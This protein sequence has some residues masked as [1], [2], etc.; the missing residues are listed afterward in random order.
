MVVDKCNG[1]KLKLVSFDGRTVYQVDPSATDIID[2]ANSIYATLTPQQR[3]LTLED[4]IGRP[5]LRPYKAML[6]HDVYFSDARNKRGLELY[7]QNVTSAGVVLVQPN[8]SFF[9]NTTSGKVISLYVQ[10]KT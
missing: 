7:V 10:E 1:D 6:L 5:D 9:I 8:F 2:V 4:V 3:S